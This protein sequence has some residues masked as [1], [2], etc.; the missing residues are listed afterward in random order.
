MEDGQRVGLITYAKY[1]QMYDFGGKVTRVH[2]FGE[3][4][5]CTR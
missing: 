3:K 2:A 1:A 5:V 4:D